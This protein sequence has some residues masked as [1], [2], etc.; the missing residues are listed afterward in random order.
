[1]PS[2]VPVIRPHK[3][4]RLNDILFSILLIVFLAI[5]L[6]SILYNIVGYSYSLVIAIAI[7]SSAIAITMF[8][9]TIR[10]SAKWKKRLLFVVYLF[11]I[12]E[13]ILQLSA[14]A[15]ILPGVNVSL[16]VP[17]SRTIGTKEKFCSGNMNRYGWYYPNFKFKENSKRILLI[18]D[19]FIDAL[20]VH[21][22]DNVGVK[23]EEL[24]NANANA[25]PSTEV[26]SLGISGTGPAQYYHI[27]RYGARYYHP[28]EAIVFICLAN[29]FRNV[30][31]KLHT[32]QP[33]ENYIYYIIDQNNNLVLDP[34][35]APVLTS[36]QN[37]LANN[38]LSIFLNV[39]LIIVS[40]SMTYA[41]IRVL[42]K[43]FRTIF[44][45]YRH[46]K[47]A[48]YDLTDELET[49]GWNSV[50]FRKKSC[51]EARES[52]AITTG[53]LKMCKQYADSQGIVFRIVTIPSFPRAFYTTY[54]STNWSFEIGEYDFSLPDHSLIELAH[55]NQIPILSLGQYMY[56]RKLP[57]DSI[58]SLYF[59]EGLGH[60][61][62]R[63]HQYLANLL[64]S[65]FYSPKGNQTE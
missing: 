52:Y 1:M 24:L 32:S 65:S 13:I 6:L 21:P 10:G 61:N 37:I 42:T 41:V 20:Q 23:L 25:T 59:Y 56:E 5:A 39:P 33:P 27:L 58:K 30:T 46:S 40:N 31:Y 12:I 16:H 44:H 50:L 8:Y 11:V 49:L 34:H 57:V 22:K 17:Y 19:S 47:V 29:D 38:H 64:F 53:L 4:H 62:Q 3:E 9:C 35:S 36:F 54:N 18:G 26:L 2:N 48:Q 51:Q 60:F 55:N 7:I 43:H 45:M 63:G 15:G 28:S 14:L